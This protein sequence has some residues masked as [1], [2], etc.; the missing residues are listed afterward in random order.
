MDNLIFQALGEAARNSEPVVLGIITSTSGSCPQ[1][2]GAKALFYPDGRILGTVG[3]GCLEAEI[4]RRA[5]QSLSTKAPRVFE[6]VLDHDFGWDDG[7]I[8]GGKVT[9]ILLPQ[10]SCAEAGFWDTL[11]ARDRRQEWG[12]T[13]ALEIAPG[14]LDSGSNW[15]YREVVAPPCSLWIAGAGHIARAVAP[16]AVMTDFC[17]TVIDDRPALADPRFFPAR[18]RTCTDTWERLLS[19]RPPETGAFGLV[20]TRGHRHD[21]IVLKAWLEMPFLFLGMIGSRRKARIVFEYFRS[22]NIAT[23]QQLERVACP[24]GLPMRSRTVAEI[25]VSIIAQFIDKRAELLG[26]HPDAETSASDRATD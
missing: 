25:A 19:M 18:T 26:E 23:Q 10:T 11:A 8:C 4:Q 6:L 5:I 13:S 2:P 14:P 15:L 3:G 22:E 16:L 12:I 24:A 9:A 1:R 7:L 21:S 17:V 20:A